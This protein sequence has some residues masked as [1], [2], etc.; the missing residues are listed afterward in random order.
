MVI[1]SGSGLRRLARDGLHGTVRRTTRT[2]DAR[3]LG[4]AERIPLERLRDP[5]LE[6]ACTHKRTGPEPPTDLIRGGRGRTSPVLILGEQGEL[7]ALRESARRDTQESHP[8]ATDLG[9]REVQRGAID[10]VGLVGGV[11]ERHL[12]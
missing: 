5:V 3:C 11:S 2:P 9:S 6:E 4:T 7:R 8:D 10:R 12:A 1:G